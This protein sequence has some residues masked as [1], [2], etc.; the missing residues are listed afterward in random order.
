[1]LSMWKMLIWFLLLL[2]LF[3]ALTT[4]PTI[5]ASLMEERQQTR[6][7]CLA[8][9]PCTGEVFF[10]WKWTNADG[11]SKMMGSDLDDYDYM[12]WHVRFGSRRRDRYG[13]KYR[14][15][16]YLSFFPTADHHNTNITCIATYDHNVAETTVTLTVKCKR[17]QPS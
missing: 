8:P 15:K 11:Q 16:N 4:K 3:A 7:T 12:R 14:G 1:M 5:L 13:M 6:L 17:L 2:L 9:T 10:L